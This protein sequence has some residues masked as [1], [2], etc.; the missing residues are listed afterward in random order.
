MKL[1]ERRGITFQDELGGLQFCTTT[2]EGALSPCTLRTLLKA[3]VIE[4]GQLDAVTKELEAL[5]QLMVIETVQTCPVIENL[6]TTYKDESSL[7]ILYEVSGGRI[8]VLLL[9]FN[10]TALISPLT[11]AQKCIYQSRKR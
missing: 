3:D 5:K 7:F 8:S 6:L 9:L 11:I 4:T 1:L 10:D 2:V